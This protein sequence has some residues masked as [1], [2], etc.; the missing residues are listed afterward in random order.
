MEFSQA[1]FLGRFALSFGMNHTN[2]PET[3]PNESTLEQWL[4]TEGVARYDAYKCDPRG[5]S[6]EKVFAQ[7]RQHRAK[8]VRACRAD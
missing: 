8:R 6:A 7:L 1:S 2:R 3:P 4:R 5:V